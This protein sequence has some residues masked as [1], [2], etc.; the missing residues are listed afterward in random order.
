MTNETKSSNRVKENIERAQ[1]LITNLNDW[2]SRIDGR[3][4]FIGTIN[5]AFIAITASF[6]FGKH[7]YKND[8]LVIL[9][10]YGAS[11]VLSAICLYFAQYPKLKSA[12]SSL[13]FFG[14][15][16]EFEQKDYL[17][18]IFN[19]SD[20]NIEKDLYIQCHI[21]SKILKGKF[22]WLKCAYYASTASLLIWIFL[23]TFIYPN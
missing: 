19:V 4:A 16:S 15:I 8:E 10:L 1:W 22:Y 12:N 5:A 17:E 14:T 6:I 21:N 7:D 20:E 2:N 3:I 18:R 23:V 13:F 9:I 11:C